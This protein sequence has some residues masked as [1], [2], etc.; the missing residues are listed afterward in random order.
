MTKW[1]RSI[2]GINV[3]IDETAD[4]LLTNN[5]G[6]ARIGDILAKQPE[7][8]ED[9][10][11]AKCDIDFKELVE[12]MQWAREDDSPVPT[13]YFDAMLAAMYDWAD[14]ERIWIEPV[15]MLAKT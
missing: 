5:E 1:T 15:A 13:S 4:S 9:E 6:I 7:F 8:V 11:D 14:R 2:K 12:E 10:C 3:V